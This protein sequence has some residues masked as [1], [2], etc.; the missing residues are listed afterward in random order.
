[1]CMTLTYISCQFDLNLDANVKKF[2]LPKYENH[3]FTNKLLGCPKM[4][5]FKTTLDG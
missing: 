4:S 1:M 3:Y 5:F 2:K